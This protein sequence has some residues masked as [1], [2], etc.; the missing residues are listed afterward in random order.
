MNTNKFTSLLLIFSLIAT[1]SLA[2][3]REEKA[4]SIL[5]ELTEKTKTYSEIEIDFTYSM[6]NKENGIDESQNGKLCLEG[7]KYRI[8]LAGQ[9][10]ISDGETIWTI[11]PDAEEVTVNSVEEDDD[12]SNPKALLGGY[13]ENFRCRLNSKESK[14]EV[15]V[16]EMSP[17]EDKT[18]FQ[19]TLFIEKDNLKIK[20]MEVFDKNGSV[21]T[22]IINSFITDKKFP[23]SII[24]FVPADYSDYEII[25]MR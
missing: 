5:K 21:Y 2:Q 14:N 25:D 6:Q 16:I 13:Y 8:E 9:I 24:N 4:N 11:L 23:E 7:D 1:I 15:Y 17:K 12:L 20:K 3:S 18:F 22:Y 19:A 10:V